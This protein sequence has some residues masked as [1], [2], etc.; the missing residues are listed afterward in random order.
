EQEVSDA[1]A[2]QVGGVVVAAQA[3]DDFGC[4]TV[5]RIRVYLHSRLGVPHQGREITNVYRVVRQ[6]D[7]G[8]VASGSSESP[9]CRRDLPGLASADSAD[10]ADS[11]S[12]FA[13]GWRSA[14][15]AERRLDRL[16][17]RAGSQDARAGFSALAF[18]G[19]GVAAGAAGAG[20][21]AGSAAAVG[22]A[23]G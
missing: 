18:V 19:S 8:N 13:A 9:G 17:S 12:G 22:S 6:S 1:P 20:S 23:A 7:G 5:N 10:S 4:V 11:S 3:L 2:Y 21:G 16:R 15:A 14:R